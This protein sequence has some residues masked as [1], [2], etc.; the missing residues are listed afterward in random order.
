MPAWMKR[1]Q[2]L[3]M[4][5][6]S[7]EYVR[8]YQLIH[9]TEM[10]LAQEQGKPYPTDAKI[11]QMTDD[12][13]KM[14]IAANLILP[15]SPKFDSPYRL[16]LDKY[17]QYQQTYG[18]NAD[19]Q[20]L[21]DFGPTFFDFATSL[22]S[23]KTGEAATQD[24]YQASNKYKGL[25]NSVFQDDPSLVG[26]IT[27]N[28]A[29]GTFSQAV[30]DWQYSTPVGPGTAETF[31][32]NANAIDAEKQ[33]KVKLGWIQYRNVMNQIDAVLQKRGLI[34]VNQSGAQDLKAIKQAM[35]D[36]L[37]Y[38]HDAQ[39]NPV[40]DKGGQPVVTPWYEAY[41]DPQGSKTFKVISGLNKIVAADSPFW[42][43]HKDNTTWKSVKTYLQV[44]NQL[45]NVL[46]K[47]QVKTITAN[48]NAD[49][50]ALYEAVVGQLKQEDIGFGDI[51]DRYLSQ[52][53]VYY[54]Y[55]SD[56]AAKGA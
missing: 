54:K 28:P 39:G 15:Y 45:S 19:T 30:Y 25:V 37:A 35:V 31:R 32:S 26:L 38:E 20:Y 12:Y 53:Q 40:L 2:T 21:K 56:V 47:R 13:Y 10:H 5:Q 50:Y 4:G 29:G 9:T 6:N 16:Y 41:L 34:S 11:K 24:A 46:A 36:T 42:Q 17:R 48:A 18:M 14:R 23:N 3:F 51:Y 43:D 33:N 8:T 52:D 1:A 7:K 44:R 22:S 55:I 49:V 27:N